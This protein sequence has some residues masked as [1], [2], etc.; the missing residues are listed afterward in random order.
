MSPK[1]IRQGE[2]KILKDILQKEAS[3]LQNISLDT[4]LD[5]NTWLDDAVVRA[6]FLKNLLVFT[7]DLDKSYNL[8]GF[9]LSQI[10]D[11]LKK[12]GLDL[13]KAKIIDV[14]DISQCKIPF[15]IKITNSLFVGTI[16]MEDAKLA[17]LKLDGSKLSGLEGEGASFSG[18]LSMGKEFVTDGSII[19]I[20]C[21][22]GGCIFCTQGT[23]KTDDA[24]P[25]S[26]SKKNCVECRKNFRYSYSLD[27]ASSIIDGDIHLCGGFNCEGGVNLADV[28]IHGNL[29]CTRAYFRA[30]GCKD[31]IENRESGQRLQ[32][33]SQTQLHQCCALNAEGIR[34]GGYAVLNKSTFIGGI[35][36]TQGKVEKDFEATE[37][38]FYNRRKVAF[39]GDRMEVAGN[40]FISDGAEIEGAIRLSNA[41][42]GADL[43]LYKIT[44]SYSDPHESSIFLRATSVKGSFYLKGSTIQKGCV[45]FSSARIEDNVDCSGARLSTSGPFALKADFVTVKGNFYF[46]CPAK[47]QSFGKCQFTEGSTPEELRF[48]ANSRVS[49]E[50]IQL[51]GNLVA[52]DCSFNSPPTAILEKDRHYALFVENSRIKGNCVLSGKQ[53]KACGGLSLTNSEIGGGAGM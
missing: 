3:E 8:S 17:D 22:F 53:F 29:N 2:I 13:S 18:G 10:R 25:P 51:D 15:P 6:D 42:V 45:D 41:L 44:S 1:N 37:V 20:N 31:E 36:F 48:I 5:K 4:P 27:I 39:H 46:T 30:N 7:D 21:T 50:G 12:T 19:L 26:P 38:K 11:N 28:T 47:L 34:V 9:D 49:L 33:E 24:L 43:N 14:L 23:F 40:V 32:C 16:R 35:R 52:R